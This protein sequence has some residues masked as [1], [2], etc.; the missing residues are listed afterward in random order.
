MFKNYYL[1]KAQ[2]GQIAPKVIGSEVVS[3]YTEYKNELIFELQKENDLFQLKL[4]LSTHKP[5]I[6]IDSPKKQKNDRL[7]FFEDLYGHTI[8]NLNM[9]VYNK[10]LTIKF[11]SFNVCACFY[12][13]APNII[14]SDLSK[15]PLESFKSLNTVI[16][17][18]NEIPVPISQALI[19]NAIS[20]TPDIKISKLIRAVCPPLNKRMVNE[21]CFRMNT[22]SDDKVKQINNSKLIYSTI[23]GFLDEINSGDCFIYKKDKQ[24]KYLTLFKSKLLLD[25]GFEVEIFK[26]INKAWSIFIY[27]INKN[28]T[29]DQLNSV[30]SNA[31]KKRKKSLET[32]LKKISFAENIEDRKQDADLKGNLILTNKHKIPRGSSSAELINIFSDNHEKIVVKLNPKKTSVENANH[33]FNKYKNIVEKKKVISLKKNMYSSELAEISKMDTK[34][35][36]ASIKELQKIKEKLIGMN[37][38][39]QGESKKESSDTLKY[40]FR[41]LILDNKWDIYIG[42]N[43]I[44]ND[45]LTFSFANKWDIWMHAQGVQG[46][47][48]II[49][50]PG[51]DISI[52]NSII[53]QAA[54]ITAANSKAKHSSTV[55]V[56]YTQ[57]RYV[58]RIRKAL[59]GTVNVRNEKV[60]FV[61][62][63]S[64]NI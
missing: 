13:T 33:Y 55:P 7:N 6:L 14:L 21:I 56:I 46:A 50:V 27:E 62:P 4:S 58:S 31:I 24:A 30:I 59:P 34:I 10:F 52:P 54:Q 36:T 47:H 12:G 32:A 15:N 23:S 18:P 17:Y 22:N 41:R 2:I 8:S 38:I 53:E 63:L 40:S 61:K 5:F 45:L 11:D 29:F 1:F 25:S 28:Q 3:V 51:K 16:E 44:N 35:Q 37:V 49:K 60:I 26:E 42:K 9:A 64:L 48:V 20:T 19:T 43:N 39:Q 57:A